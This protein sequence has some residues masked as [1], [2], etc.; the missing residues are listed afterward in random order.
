MTAKNLAICIFVTAKEGGEYVI[1]HADLIFGNIDLVGRETVASLPYS[2]TPS[3]FPD[4]EDDP[5]ELPQWDSTIDDLEPR[6]M[7]RWFEDLI[8]SHKKI[9]PNP[10]TPIQENFEGLQIDSL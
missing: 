10:R 8:S 9:T 7:R 1:R 2:E 6:L 4:L 3:A 5:V